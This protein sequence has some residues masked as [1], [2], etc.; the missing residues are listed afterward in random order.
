MI[1]LGKWIG[2]FV[3]LGATLSAK[4][5][6]VS[7]GP[8]KPWERERAQQIAAARREGIPTT[9]EELIGPSVPDDQNA[10]TYFARI[11]ADK[12]KLSTEEVGIMSD[13][14]SDYI[15]TDEQIERGRIVLTKYAERL[16]LIHGA[17]HCKV[18]SK[19]P[20]TFDIN[21]NPVALTDFVDT[22][23]VREYTRWVVVESE[24]LVHDGKPLEAVQAASLAFNLAQLA[25]SR[26]TTISYL[27]ALAID[28]MAASGM[29]RILYSAGTQAGVTDAVRT[30][31][32]TRRR[33]PKISD[34]M[35]AETVS[36]L[37]ISEN[38]R[39]DLPRLANLSADR[40]LK[41][42]AIEDSNKTGS[43]GRRYGYSTDA[44]EAVTRY[45][46]NNDTHYIGWMRR[47]APLLDLPPPE[48]AAAVETIGRECDKVKKHP[49]YMM[50]A[51]LVGSVTI[52]SHTLP[53]YRSQQAARAEILRAAAAVIEFKT[54]TGKMPEDLREA[55]SPVPTDPF[56]GDSLVYRREGEGFVV[57]SVGASRKFNGGPAGKR[58]KGNET[59]FRYPL[60]PEKAK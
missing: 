47:L 41:E 54:R 10:A 46:D 18:F 16:A 32:E 55:I 5:Q 24:I 15:P 14:S 49:D 28:A 34:C 2:A 19:V 44:K 53:V 59:L 52:F 57:Y 37:L 43:W 51:S 22:A 38:M 56:S 21:A 35:R 11:A 39:Q 48:A 36:A 42:V 3:L 4:P 26:G 33:F 30:A 9:I 6:S 7:E 27:V 40:A 58:F 25:A 31:V 23:P 60:P 12:R 13:L 45:L 17:A 8:Q 1:M 50:A 20:K 29:R